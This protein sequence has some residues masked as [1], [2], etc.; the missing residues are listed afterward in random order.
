MAADHDAYT[1]E[2][3]NTYDHSGHQPFFPDDITPDYFQV[4]ALAPQGPCLQQC[5]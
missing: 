4:L 5:A 1:T 2:N 3:L